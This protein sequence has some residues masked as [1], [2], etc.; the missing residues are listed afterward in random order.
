MLEKTY[1]FNI[2]TYF[3]FWCYIYCDKMIVDLDDKITSPHVLIQ[4][5]P[6]VTAHALV[7]IINALGL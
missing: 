6:S 7:Y 4:F 2:Y 1:I 5:Q 3:P